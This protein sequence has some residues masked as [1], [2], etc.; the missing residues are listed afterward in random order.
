LVDF[1]NGVAG[2]IGGDLLDQG[3]VCRL[4]LVEYFRGGPVRVLPEIERRLV[5]THGTE[6][7]DAPAFLGK[8]GPHI[9]S[10]LWWM[11]DC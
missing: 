4:G 1:T 7:A 9:R 5:Y 11:R 8:H 3:S 2:A 10:W 6:R